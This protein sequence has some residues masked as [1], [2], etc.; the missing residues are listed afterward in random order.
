DPDNLNRFIRAAIINEENMKSVMLN[1]EGGD[2]VTKGL[3][4]LLFIKN[5]H[6]EGNDF[7]Y[8]RIICF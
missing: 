4:T 3:D 1:R 2:S 8:A 6:D 5:G 7:I